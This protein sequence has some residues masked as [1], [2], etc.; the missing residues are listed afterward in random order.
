M[1]SSLTI[2]NVK[3]IIKFLTKEEKENDLLCEKAIGKLANSFLDDT[4]RREIIPLKIIPILYDIFAFIVTLLAQRNDNH[5]ITAQ[6]YRA[7]SNLSKDE[8][9]IQKIILEK[10]GK[11]LRMTAE[12]CS[13]TNC[14]KNCLRL[15]KKLLSKP[16][17]VKK[18]V[19]TEDITTTL[20][21][22]YYAIKTTNELSLMGINKE[23]R[24]ELFEHIMELLLII[25]NSYSNIID[26]D[27][28]KAFKDKNQANDHFLSSKACYINPLLDEKFLESLLSL[29][30]SQNSSD[31]FIKKKS[32]DSQSNN[33]KDN[34]LLHNN[35][36]SVL[37][38]LFIEMLHVSEINHALGN[39]G[40]VKVFLILLQQNL[41]KINMKSIPNKFD[42]HTG[43]H[44]QNTLF[45]LLRVVHL[46]STEVAN[47]FRIRDFGGL[48]ILLSLA[49]KLVPKMFTNEGYFCHINLII[50]IFINFIYENSSMVILCE[51]GLLNVINSIFRHFLSDSDLDFE[52]QNL[53][54]GE[55][56]V[57]K[58]FTS[59]PPLHKNLSYCE[60]EVVVLD[61]NE[62]ESGLINL[63][64]TILHPLSNELDLNNILKSEYDAHLSN[65]FSLD[66]STHHTKIVKKMSPSQNNSFCSY[67]SPTHSSPGYVSMSSPN[68]SN[69]NYYYSSTFSPTYSYSRSPP[70]SPSSVYSNY[71][72]EFNDPILNY[73]SSEEE[74]YID[75]MSS[76]SL[77]NSTLQPSS[78]LL[79]ESEDIINN[80]I[81]AINTSQL[82]SE[83]INNT[84]VSLESGGYELI[85]PDQKEI[86]SLS[87]KNNHNIC[88]CSSGLKPI[89]MP[90]H[91]LM[92][93]IYNLL[94]QVFRMYHFNPT[95]IINQ[96]SGTSLEVIESNMLDSMSL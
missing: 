57:D 85:S 37:F 45:N 38:K 78:T 31:C 75:Q 73:Y 29:Y 91:K 61:N 86:S 87:F 40:A 90:Y 66:L 44:A 93:M 32:L 48:P 79:S 58:D 94:S 52:D 25:I 60:N 14:L 82:K 15:I 89:T 19:V 76:K 6:L 35:S 1:R 62:K 53:I 22:F 11:Y 30:V 64:F 24:N 71:S 20:V 95:A 84:N 56:I 80:N 8:D 36:T 72:A 96:N 68:S 27:L 70:F 28:S 88:F 67:T 51:N 5:I 83:S 65:L 42:F 54:T 21:K 7:L 26:K 13:D 10:P 50:L 81:L 74:F 18:L 77:D 49:W 3:Q 2:D 12:K 47:K 23:K 34:L 59:V 17:Y 9:F 55:E 33:N 46:F 92:D 63:P 41:A 39:I 69:Q 4:I 43:E 16:I